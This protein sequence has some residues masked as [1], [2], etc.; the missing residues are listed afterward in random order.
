MPKHHLVTHTAHAT[1]K[2]ARFFLLFLLTLGYLSASVYYQPF[3]ISNVI[4]KIESEGE[5]SPE[6]VKQLS[7]LQ[8]RLLFS[9]ITD[10]IIKQ[11][12]EDNLLVVN[13][14]TRNFPHTLEIEVETETILLQLNCQDSMLS[15]SHR[16]VVFQTILSEKLPLVESSPLLCHK[17]LDEKIL[18]SD[19]IRAF[20]NIVDVI[21]N[22]DESMK[23]SVTEDDLVILQLSTDQRVLLT[24]SD[25]AKQFMTQELIRTQNEVGSQWTE[26]DVRF[27]K[28]ILRGIQSNTASS[29]AKIEDSTQVE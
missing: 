29:S 9:P 25:F 16:G 1:K 26:L 11:T 10:H 8:G 15:I 14:V 7:Q 5:C 6:V 13:K 24:Q 2:R 4:C 28:P 12:A 20:V 17:F 21:N 18:S 19:Q 3:V 27:D 23:F 22:N